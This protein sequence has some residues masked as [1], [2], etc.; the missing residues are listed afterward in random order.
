MICVAQVASIGTDVGLIF[1]QIGLVLIGLRAEES[2]EVV[3]ALSGGPAIEWTGVGGFLIGSNAIFAD[4][5]RVVTVVS[6]NL[7]DGA[8]CRGKSA[9]PSGEACRQHGVAESGDVNRGAVASGQERR[10]GGR[11][12]GA[13]MEVGVA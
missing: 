10:A 11:A 3:E 1:D 12:D 8:G 13:G 2:E 5:E 6:Q 4:R 7:G 9:V